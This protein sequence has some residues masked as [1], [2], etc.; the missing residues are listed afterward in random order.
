M[1]GQL[2][3]VTAMAALLLG[4]HAVLPVAVAADEWP[5]AS[6]NTESRECIDARKLADGTFNSKAR[7]MYA[8]VEMPAGMESRLVL[9]ALALDIS[10]GD[11]ASAQ[12]DQFEKLTTPDGDSN[13]SI[14]WGKASDN[15]MRL[16]ISAMPV[17]WRGDMYSLYGLDAKVEQRSFLEDLK[18]P[19]GENVFTAFVADSWRPPLVFQSS[20][21]DALWFVVVG[22]PYQIL[23]P[24]GVYRPAA[25]GFQQQCTIHFRPDDK[26]GVELLPATVHR[27]VML[28]DE[29]LGP[30]LNEGTLHPTASLR[31]DVEH[32]WGNAALR[33]WA[34]SD[35][36]AYNSRQEVDDGLRTWARGAKSFAGVYRDIQRSYPLAEQALA[37]YYQRQL[38][39]P[40][41][42]AG[43]LAHW[44]LD[45]GYRANFAFS[46]SGD[47]F[48]DDG[49][50]TN[51]WDQT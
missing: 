32:F 43:R 30:G 28:L 23:G 8:P 13:Q 16:V 17:G 47:H 49:I 6:G 12:M 39:L 40:S 10:G 36:D 24:W 51:P 27:F 19:Y 31:L 34:L 44:V 26:S 3:S 18:K 5:T 50:N 29:T 48:R 21:E 35:S 38:H 22:E 46:S 45:L 2:R 25:G 20:S 4:A 14:Y 11:A 41:A 7:R 1:T 33:P 15:G 37:R 9:G 42:R